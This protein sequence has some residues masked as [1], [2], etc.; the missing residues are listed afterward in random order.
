MKKLAKEELGR[1]GIVR[2]AALSST[3]AYLINGN[4]LH[5]LLYLP[6]GTSK[7]LPLHCDR[8]KGM[9][10]TFSNIGILFLHRREEHGR[11]EN[12]YYGQQ[13]P[14]GDTPKLQRQ[15]IWKY[16]C[17][18]LGGLQAAATSQRFSAIVL[19][20]I[21]SS[22]QMPLITADTTYTSIFVEAVTFI[23]H[24]GA[25]QADVRAQ[26]TRLVKVCLRKKAGVVN[27]PQHA[28]RNREGNLP[29]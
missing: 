17:G 23:E 5:S 22:R 28:S 6:V 10:D 3:A 24:Q 8:L 29:G 11:S 18:P 16:L 19:S 27:I 7:C 26:L 20:C 9:Q 12:I 21:G 14:P 15:A 4:T 2:A 1:D 25:D 13:K